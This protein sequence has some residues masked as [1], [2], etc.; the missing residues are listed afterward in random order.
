MLYGSVYASSFVYGLISQLVCFLLMTMVT[1]SAVVLAIIHGPPTA[2]M[3]LIGGFITP[4]ILIGAPSM[5]VLFGY[6]YVLYGSTMY[7]IYRSGWWFL[8]IPSLIATYSWLL[9]WL[10]VSPVTTHL[11]FFNPFII[12][13][14]VSSVLILQ[15]PKERNDNN[16]DAFLRS[17]DWL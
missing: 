7:L 4:S 11:L 2:V 8:S 1:A 15:V 14:M 6:M 3:A 10:Y 17:K 16:I 13:V 5:T 9:Y 12:F